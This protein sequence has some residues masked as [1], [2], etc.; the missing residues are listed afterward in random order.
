MKINSRYD[1][2]V[3]G[4]LLPR[5]L[6]EGN[7]VSRCID[8]SINA[9]ST[10]PTTIPN[11]LSVCFP[12]FTTLATPLAGMSGVDIL[13]SL[14][15]SFG[16]VFQELLE[17]PESP[18]PQEFVE[19]LSILFS[20]LDMKVLKNKKVGIAIS[21]L[22]GNTVID[23]SHKPSFT[24]G[25]AFEMPLGGACAFTLEMFSQPLI[26]SF[27]STNM[28]TIEKVIIAGDNGIDNSS[29]N[30]DSLREIDLRGSISFSNEIEISLPTADVECSSTYPPIDISFEIIRNID[31][32]FDSPEGCGH[33]DN[34]T[35]KKRFESVMIEP[36]SRELLFLGQSLHL[37]PLEHITGLVSGSTNETAIE[38]GEL[39]SDASISS[40]VKFGFVISSQLEPL[41]KAVIT[42]YIVEPHCIF[43]TVI[44]RNLKFNRSLHN[45]PLDLAYRYHNPLELNKGGE[46]AILLSLYSCPKGHPLVKGGSP[47]AM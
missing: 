15:K 33:R 1:W 28:F 34:S 42:S 3:D 14:S 20:S 38:L 26:F 23:I 36:D 41:T 40:V 12:H 18:T 6:A 16:F 2:L 30:S 43:N 32:H 17:L 9:E 35:I 7:D 25:E 5:E 21:Y 29:I 10:V 46:I 45:I 4:N 39:F 24:P 47:L 8:V 19:S 22:F 37:F 13:N 31:T 27:D 11:S 44:Q